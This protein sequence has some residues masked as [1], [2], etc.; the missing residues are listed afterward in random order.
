M[1][2]TEEAGGVL[3]GGQGTIS[4]GESCLQMSEDLGFGAV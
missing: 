2:Q 4:L 1:L 3:E